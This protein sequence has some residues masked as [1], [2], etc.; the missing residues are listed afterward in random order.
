M[1]EPVDLTIYPLLF[2]F[3]H[4]CASRLIYLCNCSFILKG[5]GSL[6]CWFC[7]GFPVLV[8]SAL[9]SLMR[10]SSGSATAPSKIEVQRKDSKS[11]CWDV[12]R[13]ARWVH[14]HWLEWQWSATVT[15]VQPLCPRWKSW[16]RLFEEQ[17]CH[18]VL[19]HLQR[20]YS[21]SWEIHVI[22]H[23]GKVKQVRLE[24]WQI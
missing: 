9:L 5:G 16:V 3:Y 22:P 1:E 18:C 17:T 23:N 8:Q 6:L 24:L 15:V 12:T 19:D 2:C 10:F 11:R 4:K 7:V 13:R 14:S 21:T 20:C